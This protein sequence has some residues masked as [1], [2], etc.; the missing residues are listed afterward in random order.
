MQV[1]LLEGKGGLAVS[2]DEVD[3]PPPALQCCTWNKESKV[4]GFSEFNLPTSTVAPERSF[5]GLGYAFNGC[6]FVV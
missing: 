2:R 5:K 3:V 1:F 6:S 4:S